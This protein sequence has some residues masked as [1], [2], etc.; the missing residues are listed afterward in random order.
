MLKK[1][2][3]KRAKAKAAEKAIEDD[4]YIRCLRNSANGYCGNR[5]SGEGPFLNISEVNNLIWAELERK[6][7]EKRHG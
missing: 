7:A 4:L 3:E 6:T 5:H 2:K 1:W